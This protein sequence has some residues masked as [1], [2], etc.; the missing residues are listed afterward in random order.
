M[1][2]I[3]L[4]SESPSEPRMRW[5]AAAAR[6]VI[7]QDTL[8]AEFQP[9]VETIKLVHADGFVHTTIPRDELLQAHFPV[10]CRREFLAR[11]AG[12]L[13]TAAL[14]ADLLQRLCQSAAVI[15]DLQDFP[16]E[17]TLVQPG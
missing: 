1:V 15:G 4:V 3:D 17:T 10:I 16:V 14:P 2:V 8:I 13:P 5:L 9:V 12:Q 7:E 11:I 6:A